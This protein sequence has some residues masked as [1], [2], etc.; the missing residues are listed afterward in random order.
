MCLWG[1]GKKICNKEKPSKAH[2]TQTVIKER[3]CGGFY[4]SMNHKSSKSS[5]IQIRVC[6][7][8]GIGAVKAGVELVFCSGYCPVTWH[9]KVSVGS[10]SVPLGVFV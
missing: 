6:M 10:S 9:R 3:N 8:T 1:L 4:I 7:T 5:D 2:K